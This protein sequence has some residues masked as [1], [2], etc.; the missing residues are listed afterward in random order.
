MTAKDVPR[1]IDDLARLVVDAALFEKRQVIALDKANI[2]AFGLI[3]DRQ[4][5]IGCEKTNIRLRRAAQRKHETRKL[6]LRQLRKHVALI[7]SGVERGFD[8]ETTGFIKACDARV[9][10]RGRFRASKPVG[11][12]QQL[13]DLAPGIA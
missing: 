1:R 2:L 10:P 6:L 9:M 3:G 7:F 12:S 4:H 13:R 8:N 11:R 5:K